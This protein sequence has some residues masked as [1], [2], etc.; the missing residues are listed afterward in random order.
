VWFNTKQTTHPE[1][2]KLLHPTRLVR[3]AMAAVVLW[4]AGATARADYPSEVLALQPLTYWRF[5]ETGT[6]YFTATN[7]GTLGPSAN[8]TYSNPTYMQGQ[9]GA[10]FGSTDTAARFDM[11]TTKIDV[12][13]DPALNPASFSIECWA[14]VD[15]GAGN[16]RSP[17]TSRDSGGNG[18]AGYIIYAGAGNTWE[19]WTGSGPGW[20]AI[21]T[22]TN[23]GPV[24]IGAWTHLV[25]TYDAASLTMSFYIN[26]VFVAERTNSTV[27]PVG[28]IGLPLPF[29]IGSGATE[30]YGNYW[31]NGRVDEVAMYPTVLTPT[32]VAANYATG[33][34]NGSAYA[35]Q[36]LA[37]SPALYM[38]LDEPVSQ[39]AVNAGSLG[40]ALNASYAAI[41]PTAINLVAPTYPGIASPNSGLVYDGIGKAVLIN[42]TNIPV[43]WTMSCWVNRQDA[44]GASAVLMY[45]SGTGIKMEQWGSVNRNV[46]FTAYGVADYTFTNYTAPVD[47]WVN[48]GFVCSSSGMLLY[49][50]GELV[51]SLPNTI[52]LPMTGIGNLSGDLLAGTVDEVAT[53][54]RALLQGQLKTA[55]LTAIGD[56]NAPAFINNVPVATPA[57]TLYATLP[58]SLNIDAYGGGPLSYQW[59]KDGTVVGTSGTYTVAAASTAHNGNY[60]VIVGNSHGSITSAVLN[61]SINPA[62]PVSIAQQPVARQV[63]ATGNASFTVTANGTVP[64]TYQWKKNGANIGGATNATLVITNVGSGDVATYSVGVTNVAGGVVS[65]GAALTLRTPATGSY[66]AAVVNSKPAS[67][68]RLGETTGTTAY[69]Y[70]G[71][72]DAV[73]TNVTLGVPGYSTS[74]PNTAVGYDPANPNGPGITSL[75]DGSVF[76]LVGANPSFSLEAWV[77][78]NDLAGVQR[79]FSYAGPGFHGIGFGLNTANGLRFTTYGVQDYNLTLPSPVNTGTWYHLVGVANGSTFYFYLNGVLV[80]SIASTGPGIAPTIPSPFGIGRNPESTAIEAVNGTIDEAAVYSRALTADEILTHYSL[81]AYGTTT[82]PFVTQNPSGG[83]IVVGTSTTLSGT[84]LGSL[85]MTFQ[86]KKDGV[87][88]PGATSQTLTL[89]NAYYTAGGNYVLWATNNAGHTNTATAAVV[90]L[91]PPSFANLTNGVVLHLSFDGTLADSSGSAND[92]AAVGTVPFIAGKIGQ[93]AHIAT[94]PGNNYLVVSDIAGNLEFDQTMSFTVSFWVNYT[95]RFNDN[96][97]IGN[98]VNSTWQLGWVYTDEGGK[99]EWSLVST[100][101]TSTYLR[102]PVGPL[103]IGDGLWHNV[104]G[105]VDREKQMAFA[106]VDGVLD[107]SWSIAGLGTL[108]TT[109]SI[110][111]GQDP[112]GAY[113]TET[114][115]IDDIGIWSKALSAYEAASIYGAAQN[116]ESFNVYGPVK[117]YAT[118]VGTNLDLAW[119]AGTLMQST[120]AAGPYTAVTPTVTGPYYRTPTTG[121]AMFYRVRLSP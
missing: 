67:Y 18:S 118:Q 54:N 120:N 68:W 39:S 115:D 23:T 61:V 49:A 105:V 70:M 19:F 3:T 117:L 96:P 93:A 79:V 111:I 71:G 94:T 78:W 86:W 5:N 89:T 6:F 59:R 41:Q 109:Y 2:M 38:R 53:F 48:L 55:Y 13:F 92:A 76:P 36:V 80:G 90:V 82:P 51:D 77:N 16:Y 57:G 65:T 52:T 44:P 85:P 119:Q 99:L 37:L 30:G 21:T 97:I 121:P 73:Y 104:V 9:P 14:R 43:P 34:T 15:G 26:G 107:G 112:T 114:F 103:V 1:T 81:G 98:A 69:D 31:F 27:V 4:G 83:S 62:V 7:R 116:G 47:T 17:V 87:N 45:S 35:A 11:A 74:D 22:T 95:G 101:N 20:N 50:N 46:G 100:A 10:L 88:V 108:A 8:G 32:Q 91:P 12:P 60:D 102:D 56:Q 58:F 72:H 42:S 28:S 84:I 25:G 24:V 110:T 106:Y 63:Y 33:T 29:R 66:E 40:T 75:P 64:Y 113:G